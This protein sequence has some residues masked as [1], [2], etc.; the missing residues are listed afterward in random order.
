MADMK[1]EGEEPVRQHAR[2]TASRRAFVSLGLVAGLLAAVSPIAAADPDQSADGPPPAEGPG[3]APGVEQQ[4]AQQVAA[5]DPG[6]SQLILYGAIPAAAQAP[7]PPTAGGGYVPRLYGQQAVET[8]IRRGLTQ[9]GH[10]YSWGGGGAY[11][12]SRGVH[13]GGVADRYGDYNISGYDCSGLMVFSF[14]GAGVLLPKYS[15]NQYRSGRH[16]PV[17]QARRGDMLFY[18]P[19][20]TQ[21]VALYLGNGWMLESPESGERVHVTRVRTSGICPDAVRLF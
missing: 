2:S 5:Q 14:A 9:I 20:G 8:V 11:G 7:P 4:L 19:N 17:S 10:I 15:G 21:H 12:P 6:L 18:G 1:F 13:D 3:A 16:V